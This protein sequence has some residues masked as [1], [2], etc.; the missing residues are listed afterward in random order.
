MPDALADVSPPSRPASHGTATAATAGTGDCPATA[1][2]GCT[3]YT[4]GYYPAGIQAGNVAIFHP[5]V[6]YIEGGVSGV[7]FGTKT[8]GDMI[9]CSTTCLADTSGCC[10]NNGML[11]YLTSASGAMNVT[12]NVS[13]SLIGSD[14]SSSYKGLLFFGDR[15]SPSATVRGPH[16]LNASAGSLTL[17][18]TTYLTNTNALMNSSPSVYQQ[19]RLT[20]A[21]TMLIKGEIIVSKLELRSAANI[22]VQLDSGNTSTFS[23][24]QVAVV[25]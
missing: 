3:V 10:R 17:Q 24:D 15:E 1:A 25:D 6:Y 12:S 19:L 2:S 7:G 5:G 13:T 9:M 8:G 23:A 11:V 20:G 16:I 4:P 22:T 21:G 14:Q 18:G